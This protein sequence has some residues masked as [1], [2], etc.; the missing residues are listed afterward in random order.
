MKSYKYILEGLDCASC[1]KKIED[2]IANIN[3]YKEVSVNFA[4]L[5]LYF[6]TDQKNPKKEITKLIKEIEPDVNVLEIDSHNKKP[7][8]DIFRLTIGICIYCIGIFTQLNSN[9]QIVFY[10]IAIL[11]LLFRTAKKALVQIRKGI[12]DENALITISVIGACFV[13]KITEAVMVIALYEIGKILESRAINKT[14]RSISDL[15]DIK[16]E[17]A[18]LKVGN[19]IKKVSPDTIKMGDIILVKTGEKI[20]LD[21]VVVKGKAQIDTSALTGESFL[22]EVNEN[23][24]ILS[25]SINVDG[26]IEVKVEKTY[27]KLLLQKRQKYIHLLY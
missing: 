11:T 3:E 25:G 5:K 6:K 15:M 17:Y 21:G 8:Y 26:L 4:T 16:P 19:N 1:A 2:K 18:N 23:E 14:R 20:P 12:F 27:E 13:N 24:Q 7:N 22:K 10:A 9:I